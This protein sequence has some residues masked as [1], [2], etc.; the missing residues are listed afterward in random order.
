MR[1]RIASHCRL[2]ASPAMLSI[3]ASNRSLLMVLKPKRRWMQ[4]SL[5]TLLVL[6]TALCIVLSTVVVPGERQ[7]RT[8]ESLES[9]GGSITYA[10]DR[11][12]HEPSFIKAVL[13]KWL[14]TDYLEDVLIVNLISSAVTD[15]T[16]VGLHWLKGAKILR[17]G[18]TNVTDNGLK[19]LASMTHLE[20]LSLNN[21]AISDVG[22]EHIGRLTR[23][24]VLDL[25][26]TRVTDDGIGHLNALQHLETLSLADTG[27]TDSGIQGLQPRKNLKVLD[28]DST[29]ITDACLAHLQEFNGLQSLNVRRTRITKAGA[30]RFNQALPE[31]WVATRLQWRP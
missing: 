3:M 2:I 31:C 14:P 21:T 19:E 23:L 25:D 4:F 1:V 10:A 16:L 7:R 9:I 13:R 18:W 28:L 6:V 26:H 17:L 5:G 11:V 8:V 20:E 15:E 29:G 12:S 30:A 24:R 27:V 22:L